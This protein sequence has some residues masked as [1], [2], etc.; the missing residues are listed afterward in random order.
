MVPPPWK[1]FGVLLNGDVSQSWVSELVSLPTSLGYSLSA[2]L[3]G[4]EHTTLCWLPKQHHIQQICWSEHF[5]CP[6]VSIQL[7]DNQK[8]FFL[9]C[10]HSLELKEF[11]RRFETNSSLGFS[12]P[13]CN[14]K[15]AYFKSG[16]V[17]HLIHSFVDETVRTWDH[18]LQ[19]AQHHHVLTLTLLRAINGGVI[20][21]SNSR[22]YVMLKRKS[23]YKYRKTCA[24]ANFHKNYTKWNEYY[25]DFFYFFRKSQ[26]KNNNWVRS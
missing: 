20:A 14:L 13:V 17:K 10:L 18:Q 5:R 8:I 15:Y 12:D 16:P 4:S 24:T 11:P 9:W 3:G 2:D 7:F 22:H 1:Y 25:T 26:E 23:V 6:F 21:S 19:P